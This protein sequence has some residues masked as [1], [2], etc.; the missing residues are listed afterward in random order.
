MNGKLVF[1]MK[2]IKGK[3][4]NP[5]SI[6]NKNFKFLL[7]NQMSFYNK[8]SSSK[9][10]CTAVENEERKSKKST[11]NNTK[12]DIENMTRK[13]NS[14]YRFQESKSKFKKEKEEKKEEE[15]KEKEEEVEKIGVVRKFARGFVKL[16]KHTFPGEI[17]Y[18]S[19]MSERMEEA[20]KLKAKIKYASEEEI[21]KFQSLVADWKKTAVILIHEATEEKKERLLDFYS[22][23]ILNQ[24]KTSEAYSQVKKSN[25]F[26][27]YEQFKDDLD[28]I[29][30]NI[31]DNI[32]MSYNPAV[33]VAKD[34]VVRLKFIN[35]FFS[36]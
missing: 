29:K 12:Q 19:I 6:I 17:D 7:Q 28:V 2:N 14:L 22:N 34:L 4:F 35:S 16:W 15:E 8:Y 30:S 20:K 32:A 26:K 21:E 24:I 23:K 10:L 5:S 18:A 9:F 13:L 31:K 27:E 11:S 1:N 36:F 25:T 3:K 33:I